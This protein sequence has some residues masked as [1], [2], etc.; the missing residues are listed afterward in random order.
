MAKKKATK[1]K[2]PSKPSAKHAAATEKHTTPK[3]RPL[4]TMEQS[5]NARLERLC[6]SIGTQREV[7]NAA[8]TT[9]RGDIQAA[10]QEMQRSG[11][12]VFRHG[13]VE[14][15]RIPGADKLRVRV[16]D[17]EGGASVDSPEAAGEE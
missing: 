11:L 12:Q 1:P 14:L 4:P 3:D 9:E 17:E 15:A 5:K 2:R 8:K 16:T 7:I 10:L 13:G 6:D